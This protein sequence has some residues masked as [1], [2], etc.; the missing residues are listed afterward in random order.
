[1]I[2]LPLLCDNLTKSF[3]IKEVKAIIRNMNPKKVMG[4]DLK[5]CNQILQKLPEMG[6]KY[7][8]QLYNA[9]YR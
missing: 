5:Y 1:M 4:Y 8:T 3:T 6:I 7:I 2:Q 9:I